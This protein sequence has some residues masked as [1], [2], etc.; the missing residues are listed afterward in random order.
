MYTRIVRVM[1]ALSPIILLRKGTHAITL[2]HLQFLWNHGNRIL[3]TVVQGIAETLSCTDTE[4]AMVAAD[5]PQ[6]PD[7]SAQCS[8]TTRNPYA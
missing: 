5:W 2:L 1:V 6:A 3:G 4:N 7:G 8:L